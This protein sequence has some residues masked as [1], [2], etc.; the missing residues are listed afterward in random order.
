MAPQYEP[1]PRR[2]NQDPRDKL[3]QIRAPRDGQDLQDGS[4]PRRTELGPAERNRAPQ[5]EPELRNTSESG[6]RRT[7]QGSERQIRALC[8]IKPG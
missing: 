1:G 4:G 6:P 2:T 7:K 8:E 5:N 3:E